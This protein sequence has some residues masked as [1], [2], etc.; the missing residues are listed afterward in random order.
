MN[1]ERG[2]TAPGKHASGIYNVGCYVFGG[3]LRGNGHFWN[4][5]LHLRGYE[6]FGGYMG[7]DI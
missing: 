5:M 3:D 6:R 1:T 4:N 2:G 7:E